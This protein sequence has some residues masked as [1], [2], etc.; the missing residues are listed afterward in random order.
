MNPKFEDL[1]YSSGFTTQ[2]CWEELD[3][4]TKDAIL[5][6]G[7]LVVRECAGICEANDYQNILQHFFGV[8]K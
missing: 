7:E 2:G 1:L 5:R 4:Y 3:D 8:A 6:Y